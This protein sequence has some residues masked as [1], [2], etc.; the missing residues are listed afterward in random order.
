MTELHRHAR[1]QLLAVILAAISVTALYLWS[2]NFMASSAGFAWLA[3]PAIVEAFRGGR[4]RRPVQDERDEMIA[5]RATTIGYSAL[6][7]GLVVWGVSVPL[8]FGDEGVV[9]LV[10]VAPVLWVA[11]WTVAGVRAIA[12]LVLDGRD[13]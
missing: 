7:V 4:T 10:W 9:P 12:I 6:W 5:Q 1:R 2:S 11:W 8:V 13:Q 3:L